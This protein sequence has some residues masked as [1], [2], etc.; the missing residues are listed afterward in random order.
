MEGRA[1]SINICRA[2]S[3]T[4]QVKQ[5]LFRGKMADGLRESKQGNKPEQILMSKYS[6]IRLHRPSAL[7]FVFDTNNPWRRRRCCNQS[8]YSRENLS[9]ASS[10]VS[11]RWSALSR[12]IL[13]LS[14]KH[15]VLKA[16]PQYNRCC[17]LSHDKSLWA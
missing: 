12:S 9:M 15:L 16:Y 5:I 6:I 8:A 3:N 4:T 13:S 17:G 14:V 2:S 11:S 1:V 7:C 10:F